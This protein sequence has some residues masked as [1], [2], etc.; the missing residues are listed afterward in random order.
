MKHY[1]KAD[2]DV[3]LHDGE[4][5]GRLYLEEWGREFRIIDIAL[6]PAWRGLGIGARLMGEIIAKAMAAGKAVSIH[7]EQYNPA[8]SFYQRLGF[9]K[10]EDQGVYHLMEHPPPGKEGE[11]AA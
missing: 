2:F 6:L 5:I 9:K 7:V 11:H 8:M 10:V 3:I 4:A 1:P